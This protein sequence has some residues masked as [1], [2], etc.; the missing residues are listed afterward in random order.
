MLMMVYKV[1]I[2]MD[3]VKQQYD[4]YENLGLQHRGDG[5]Y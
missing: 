4:L 3:D 1:V 2:W 5:F